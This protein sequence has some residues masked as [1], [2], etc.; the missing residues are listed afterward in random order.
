MSV[1]KTGGIE[2]PRYEYKV[3]P[4]PDKG[5][6]TKGAKGTASR[7]A[8]TLE[9]LMNEHGA[10]GWEYQRT[11]TLPCQERVGL[12]GKQT[13]FQHMLV[14][15]REMGAVALRDDEVS[16]LLAAP[17]ATP[18]LEAKAAAE[19]P[20]PEAPK[21]EV[22][23]EEAAESES[24]ATDDETPQRGAKAAARAAAAA[25][26]ARSVEGK[27]PAVGPAKTDVAAE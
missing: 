11:D 1:L 27:A 2:M 3:V 20:K 5:K 19:A 21:H 14:F 12:T 4:A 18:Q 9:E 13:S 16:G 23:S 24:P 7:F 15:R 25:L 17:E 22:T 10:E 8:Q 26:S 6:R